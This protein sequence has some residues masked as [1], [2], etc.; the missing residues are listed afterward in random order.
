MKIITLEKFIN[1]YHEIDI[2][3]LQCIPIINDDI[4]VY[5][6]YFFYAPSNKYSSLEEFLA[7][8]VKYALKNYEYNNLDFSDSIEVTFRDDL[9]DSEGFIKEINKNKVISHI[10]GWDNK[11]SDKKE[12]YKVLEGMEHTFQ[13]GEMSNACGGYIF[14]NDIQYCLYEFFFP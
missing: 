8:C 10:M 5:T 14:Y 1:K 9:L 12:M 3:P 2:K 11:E 7:A 6:G 4:N 13:Y